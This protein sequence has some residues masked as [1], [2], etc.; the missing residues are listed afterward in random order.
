MD[1]RLTRLL[2]AH[3]TL[4]CSSSLF[5]ATYYIS[6]TGSDSNAGTSTGVPW[7]TPNHSGLVCGDVI[8]AAA[9]T[10]YDH[11]SFYQTYGAV[12][13][14][15]SNNVVMITCV[16]PYACSAANPDNTPT[17]AIDKPYWGVSGWTCT[18][19]GTN[20]TSSC[21]AVSPTFSTGTATV[22]HV[23]FV[24][25]IVS[26]SQTGGV[27]GYNGG[28]DA[29]KVSFDY[30]AVV[31]NI[32][33]NATQSNVQC[34]SGISFYQPANY[35][36][37]PGTHLF[38]AGNFSFGNVD[39]S[40]CGGGTATDGNGVIVDSFDGSP[41]SFPAYTGQTVVA[42]NIL[43]SNGGRGITV[44]L[45]KAGSSHAPI[46]LR[47]NTLWGNNTALNQ[48]GA[49]CGEL[50]VFDALNVRAYWNILATASQYGC[51][52]SNPLYSLFVGGADSS[53][54]VYV[55]VGYSSSQTDAGLGTNPGF[56]LGNNLFRVNPS[57]VS[58]GAPSAPSC[59]GYATTALCMASLIANFT[60]TN[61]L[62]TSYG[63][64]APSSTPVVDPLYPQWLC[65]VSIPSGLVTAGC[66]IAPS[67]T[68]VK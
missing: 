19:T 15:Q 49:A 17:F 60:S 1:C 21:F 22:H 20:T 50:Q 54:N 37:L 34:Y 45:N 27:I 2:A 55:N 51:A 44:Y 30:V 29:A 8:Q 46:I 31:G 12:T 59:S 62:A 67:G 43:V 52:T 9:S 47:N 36:T 7:L 42:N 16:T 13:C 14:P 24:N 48:S 18:T 33:Y 23:V 28:V 26:G 3:L 35:D 56:N 65:N 38:V 63:Y 32:V 58:A 61:A 10:A 53:V 66:L 11:Y 57:F 25:N 41:A 64:Q 40:P 39:P 4:L 68:T 5:G 6:P